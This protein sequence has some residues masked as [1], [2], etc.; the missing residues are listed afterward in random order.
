MAENFQRP[1]WLSYRNAGALTSMQFSESVCRP[2]SPIR[3]RSDLLERNFEDD[4]FD[5]VNQG[6]QQ[7]QLLRNSTTDCC[8]S[9]GKLLSFCNKVG[10]L[11]VCSQQRIVPRMGTRRSLF[12]TDQKLS[13]IPQEQSYSPVNEPSVQSDDPVWIRQMDVLPNESNFRKAIS[14]RHDGVL[15]A[16]K[17]FLTGDCNACENSCNTIVMQHETKR[18]RLDEGKTK[19]T[20]L[21][22]SPSSS[23]PSSSSKQMKIFEDNILTA[24]N[25]DHSRS[26]NVI[27]AHT[28]EQQDDKQ[29]EG[30]PHSL[31]QLYS[32][33]VDVMYTNRTNL[34]HTIMVQQKLFEQ[35]IR[36]NSQNTQMNSKPDVEIHQTAQAIGSRSDSHA[37][38]SSVSMEW[39]LRRRPDGS[40]Y[41]T[42]RPIRRQILKERAQQLAKER[43]GITT[44]DDSTSEL[45]LGRYWSRDK[46]KLHLEQARNHRQQKELIQKCKMETVRENGD[47]PTIIE[48]SKRKAMRHKH[49]RIM[50]N[51][52]TVQEMLAHGSQD[53]FGQRSN[54]LLSVTTV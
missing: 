25:P 38:L 48:L 52:V 8:L 10:K 14:I 26:L 21:T 9:N 41:V 39:V 42:R 4:E 15:N 49:K 3:R 13:P 12:R 6:F 20:D 40:R 16:E 54:P 29:S 28:G 37:A 19:P 43:C 35:Q 31:Q 51:F 2:K 36:L 44:D 53:P 45:K 23:S 17:Y 11:S 18:Y 50:D 7:M 27:M 34:E 33:Y 30:Q 47:Q 32:Q 1:V 5:A 24:K 22:S 46:R